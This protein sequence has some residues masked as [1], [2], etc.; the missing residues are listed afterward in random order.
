[1]LTAIIIEYLRSPKLILTIEPPVDMSYPPDRPAAQA[2]YLH[3][4]CKNKKPSRLVSWMTREAA[5]DCYGYVSFSDR[6]GGSIFGKRMQL[7]W[8]DTPQPVPMEVKIG[9]QTGYV[10]DPNRMVL[11]SRADIHPGTSRPLD[12]AVKFDNEPECYGWN[13]ENYFSAPLWRNPA[14]RLDP[15]DY[16]VKVVVM[17]GGARTVDWFRLLNSGGPTEF[18]L[19]VPASRDAT[20]FDYED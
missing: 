4:L 3:V 12:T 10:L 15:G 16:F 9:N 19:E 2:R 18:R 11:D 1:M 5:L 13:N 17:S 6:Q 7:R 8:S 14:W 20:P